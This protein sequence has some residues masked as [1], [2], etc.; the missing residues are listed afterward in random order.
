MSDIKLI[1]DFIRSH[2]VMSLATYATQISVCS[3]FYVYDETNRCFVVASSM[4]TT[5]IKDILQNNNVAGN[6]FLE[7]KEVG[8][9]QGLQ[10]KGQFYKCEDKDKKKLYFKKFPYA[11]A[12]KPILWEIRVNHF[13]YTD[14]R[15]GFGKKLVLNF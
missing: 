9:I 10:F 12:L 14:N 5:H 4:E 7:T 13:K 1:E 6:I 2:H 11:L 15:L 8:K 3:L